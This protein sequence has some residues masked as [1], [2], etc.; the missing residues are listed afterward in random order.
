MSVTEAKELAEKSYKQWPG[1]QSWTKGAL[2]VFNDEGGDIAIFHN[3]FFDYPPDK[4]GKWVFLGYQVPKYEHLS[5]SLRSLLLDGEQTEYIINLVEN[6]HFRFD[7]I[8]KKVTSE[9]PPQQTKSEN[10]SNWFGNILVTALVVLLIMGF[11]ATL[12]MFQA[13]SGHRP[14]Y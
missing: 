9:V 14:H 2:I 6:P 11:L 12:G 3:N 13:L 8:S 1:R 4:Y 10:S 5:P 7:A